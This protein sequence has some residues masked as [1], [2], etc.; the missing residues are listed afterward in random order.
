MSGFIAF[1]ALLILVVGVLLYS[2]F[3]LIRYIKNMVQSDKNNS[4]VN[5]GTG[6]TEEKRLPRSPLMNRVV[7]VVILLLFSW[8]PLGLVDN[9]VSER[10]ELYGKVLSEI[11]GSW[12]NE[13]KLIG[14]F[15][16]VP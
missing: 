5:S 14:P 15:L 3:I 13:Q 11:S 16:M 2:V 6:S 9:L 8:L 12:G 10:H 4:S 7:L 1:A